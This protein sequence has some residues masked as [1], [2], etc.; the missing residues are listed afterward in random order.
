MNSIT[1]TLQALYLHGK[2]CKCNQSVERFM[3][4]GA[5]SIIYFQVNLVQF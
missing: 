4:L 3:L 5:S 2:I 1:K